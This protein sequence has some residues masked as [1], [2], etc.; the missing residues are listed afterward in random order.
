MSS[1]HSRK[2]TLKH[3]SI[4]VSQ[5]VSG[6]L[7]YKFDKSQQLGQTDRKALITI[8]SEI[9]LETMALN[10]AMVK[11]RFEGKNLAD[12]DFWTKSDPYL[13]LS[14][15]ASKGAYDF[16]KVYISNWFPLFSLNYLILDTPN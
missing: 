10:Q 8:V 15:P 9:I 7:E 6:V 4:S 5:S 16:K 14:R 13:V 2:S 1:V 12:C 11:I 3:L